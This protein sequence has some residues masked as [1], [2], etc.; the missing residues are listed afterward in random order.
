MGLTSWKGP[1]VRKGD[2][3]VAKNYLAEKEISS[4]NRLVTMFL[5]FAEDRALRR[6]Q[7]TMREWVEQTDQFLKF[8][9]RDVLDGAGRV[10]HE[11]MLKRAEE[12]YEKFK[13]NRLGQSEDDAV[14]ELQEIAK[15]KI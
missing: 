2:I 5:D 10:S 15:K 9:E 1:Q 4:L 7:I 11:H 13:K 12:E 14:V 3:E 8:N 6:Q